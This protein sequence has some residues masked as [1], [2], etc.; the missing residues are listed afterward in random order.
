[1]I[2]IKGIYIF[3]NIVSDYRCIKVFKLLVY[4]GTRAYTVILL[5]ALRACNLLLL[6]LPSC[7]IAA[8]IHRVFIEFPFRS[9]QDF[10]GGRVGVNN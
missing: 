9:S 8:A 4:L 10:K 7:F 5:R 6:R 3:F 1:M 2:I